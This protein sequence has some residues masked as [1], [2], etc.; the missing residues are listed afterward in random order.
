[1]Q[2]ACMTRLHLHVDNIYNYKKE[3]TVNIKNNNPL[4]SYI[5]ADNH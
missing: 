4:T 3:K 5:I 2:S 1:M